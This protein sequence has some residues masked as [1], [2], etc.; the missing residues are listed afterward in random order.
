MCTP[1]RRCNSASAK[2]LFTLESPMM[3]SLCRETILWGEEAR[4]VQRHLG[5]N[6]GL[7]PGPRMFRIAAE[8][9][10]VTLDAH[11]P[12]QCDDQSQTIFSPSLFFMKHPSHPGVKYPWLGSRHIVLLGAKLCLGP[13]C[14]PSGVRNV[15]RR[16]IRW[17]EN[18][19]GPSAMSSQAQ[20][21]ISSAWFSSQAQGL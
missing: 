17:A 16:V 8:P 2:H 10:A 1:K 19:A 7:P 4:S 13:R 11:V 6:P 12:L 14:A 18:I 15:C 20:R 5:L 21:G 9:A 3:V